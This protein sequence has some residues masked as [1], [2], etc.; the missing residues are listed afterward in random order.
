ME[1]IIHHNVLV[2]LVKVTARRVSTNITKI[3][4]ENQTN[5]KKN[6]TIQIKTVN[7]LV[8][9]VQGDKRVEK[10]QT[11]TR[12]INIK[13]NQFSIKNYPKIQCFKTISVNQIVAWESTTNHKARQ[14]HLFEKRSRFINYII[15]ELFILPWMQMNHIRLHNSS[16]QRNYQC[17]PIFQDQSS[18]YYEQSIHNLFC[19]MQTRRFLSN[20]N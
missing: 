2:H 13:N 11:N 18:H 10:V 19:F 12:K 1:Q 15:Y 7:Q 5:N 20:L 14:K 3:K 6:K 17:F 8:H 9:M 4:V 16:Y